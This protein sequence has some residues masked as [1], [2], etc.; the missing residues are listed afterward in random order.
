MFLVDMMAWNMATM[1][2]LVNRQAGEL[3]KDTMTLR[4][5]A[6][7]LGALGGYRLRGPTPASV[8]CDVSVT[9]SLSSQIEIQKGT[10]VRSTTDLPFE[11]ADDYTIL[12]GNTA[13]ITQVVVFSTEQVGSNVLATLVKVTPGS[14]NVDLVDSSIDLTQYVSPGQE[15][16]VDASSLSYTISSISASDGAISNNRIILEAAYSGT[17]EAFVE[18]EVI[19]RRIALVQG[20]TVS[21]QF[22]APAQDTADFLVRLSRTPVIDNTVTVTVNDEAWTEVSSPLDLSPTKK[23]FIVKTTTSGVTIVQFGDGQLGQVVPA[24]SVIGVSYRVGGGTAGNVAAGTIATSIIGFITSSQN[25][26]TINITNRTSSGQGGADEE[27]LEEARTHIPLYFKANDRAVTIDDCQEVARSFSSPQFGAVSFA[28]A[29][30]RATNSILEGNIIELYAWTTGPGGTLTTLSS[31]MKLALK[32]WMNARGLGT[33]YIMI[34][35]GTSRPVPI[36]FRFKTAEGFQLSDTLQLLSDAIKSMV[37]SLRPGDPIVYSDLINSLATTQGVASVIMATPNN[38]LTTTSP[39]ELFTIPQDNYAYTVVKNYASDI[40]SKDD[41][42]RVTFYTVQLPVAPLTPW[43]FSLML[44]DEVLSITP[45]T[46]PGTARLYNSRVLSISDSYLSYVNLLTGQAVL[47]TKGVIGDLTMK[48]KT[49]QGYNSDRFINIYASYIGLD[50][51]EKRQEIRTRI[52]SWGEGLNIG[53]TLYGTE[54]S[55]ITISK[56]NIQSVIESVSDVDE[57]T[58]LTL[59]TP[60]NDDP[61]MVAGETELLRIGQIILNG[62]PN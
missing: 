46:V 39:T 1:A 19:D 17:E 16:R 38:D 43:A 9:A 42:E 3:Y 2:F 8:L 53:G 37:N 27:S 51:A 30:S 61:K 7:R 40:D 25:P 32:E 26:V 31:A 22:T 4:E 34:A 49:M 28:R 52:K 57:V 44:G 18:A 5:S 15:F 23:S 12:I 47:A 50:S 59:G 6:I 24:N 35:D 13:P 54:V 36:A 10:L 62:S 41:G 11:I 14:V 60:I 45:G 33:D 21:E 58:K 20:Q 56:S 55:E 48:L 29:F